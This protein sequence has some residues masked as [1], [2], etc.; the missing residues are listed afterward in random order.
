M[1]LDG[2]SLLDVDQLAADLAADLDGGPR[3]D[4]GVTAEILA[5]GGGRVYHL[6]AERQRR[7]G[8]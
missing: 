8:A 6:D 5:A 3:V 1:A 4:D 7:R 2:D